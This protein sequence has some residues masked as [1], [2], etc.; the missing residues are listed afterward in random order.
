ML[1]YDYEVLPRL[2]VVLITVV[3]V[4]SFAVGFYRYGR[5]RRPNASG[6]QLVLVALILAYLFG[7]LLA[8]MTLIP[9]DWILG[10][11]L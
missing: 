9:L 6:T 1:L 11:F 4:V 5:L 10:R 8:G 2:A 3:V 7:I